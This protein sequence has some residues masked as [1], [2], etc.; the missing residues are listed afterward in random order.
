[1]IH[2]EA[3]HWIPVDIS[4]VF[5]FF[6]DPH[7][8]PPIMPTPLN[9]RIKALKLV[10]PPGVEENGSE[11]M[12]GMGS[13]ITL[14]FKVFPPLPFRLTWVS[15]ITEFR[16]NSYFTDIQRRGPMKSWHHSH[17][18]ARASKNGVPGTLLR[19]IID[20]EPGYGFP[21]KL[22]GGMMLPTQLRLTFAY[23]QKKIE[24]L[25]KP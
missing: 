12:A 4:K 15:L 8:L 20:A 11:Q 25:L 3:E 22:F 16:W 23:R 13:E 17:E 24:E 5:A 14:S 1:M 2:F 18:F 10:P 19:D 9:T 6:A 7:N 21:G